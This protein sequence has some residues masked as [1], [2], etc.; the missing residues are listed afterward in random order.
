MSK[1]TEAQKGKNYEAGRKINSLKLWMVMFY[2]N[3]R[4]TRRQHRMHWS[5]QCGWAHAN[6]PIVVPAI[7]TI[8]AFQ[9]VNLRDCCVHSSALVRTTFKEKE[10]KKLK[11][12]ENI[13]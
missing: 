8:N 2:V 4:K 7:P 10:K 6:I 1:E 3:F 9:W 11:E 12:P 13:C 5:Q